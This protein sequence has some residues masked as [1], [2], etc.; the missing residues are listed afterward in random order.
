MGIAVLSLSGL[1]IALYMYLYKIG[2]IGTL[3]CGTGSCETVQLSPQARFLGV[4]VAL[5]G[6]AGYTALF[7]LALLALQPRF[8]GAAW[9]SRLLAFLAGGAVLFTAY[10]TYLELFVIHAICRWCVAS[11][12]IILLTFGLSLWDLR[13]TPE[14]G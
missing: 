3:A 12:A 13:R 14:P 11:A 4:E 8:S 9:P 7:G 6:V 2:K 10:L 5:I 1:F